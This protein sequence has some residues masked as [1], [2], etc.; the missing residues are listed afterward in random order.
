[1]KKFE[2]VPK[3]Y[4]TVRGAT[5]PFE[6]GVERLDFSQRLRAGQLLE[7]NDL[8]FPYLFTRVHT[9]SLKKTLLLSTFSCLCS[10][11]FL[12][13]Y[14]FL[15]SPTCSYV[16]LPFPTFSFRCLLFPTYFFLLFIRF[17]TFSYLFLCFPTFSYFV[18]PFPTCSQLFLPF[19]TLSY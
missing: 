18:L 15:L 5:N 10:Y 1:M 11:L 17:H 16:F 4:E 7:E 13:S 14:V 12:R 8:L 3:T 2:N 6:F 19:Q 9:R